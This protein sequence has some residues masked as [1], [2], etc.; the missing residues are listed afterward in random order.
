V[1]G[2]RTRNGN[3]NVKPGLDFYARDSRNNY[4]NGAVFGAASD[5]GL[6]NVRTM[7]VSGA[8]TGHRLCGGTC[9]D[10]RHGPAQRR[11]EDDPPLVG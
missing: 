6:T 11:A 4:C 10:V 9:T 7:D 3:G 2:R 8:F 1:R 5:S